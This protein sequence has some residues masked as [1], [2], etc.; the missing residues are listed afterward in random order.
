MSSSE[1][2]TPVIA[3]RLATVRERIKAAAER[4]GRD[5]ASIAVIAVSKRKPAEDIVA[6]YEAGQ[7]DFGE[8]YV[9]EFAAKHELLPPLDDARFHFIGKLQS[10]KAGKAAALFSTIHTLDS[11]KLARRLDR[12]GKPLEVFLEVK[13]SAEESKSGMDPGLLE[14][15]LADV[16]AASNLR[17]SGLM[18]MPPWNADPERARP[19]FRQL[20]E[21]AE[22]HGIVGLSMGMSHDL[23]VAIDEG[24]THLRIGTAIFG[25]RDPL[26]G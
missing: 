9:Q 26:P 1:H 15:V 20:R 12:F 4:V 2:R 19:Y 23:E 5:P 17:L 22:R 24:A 13:L 16:A 8:N 6:A 7:R 11:S 18:T 25:P 14:A 21:L 10:N 3:A